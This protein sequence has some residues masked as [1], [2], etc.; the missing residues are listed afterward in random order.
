MTSGSHLSKE[1][2]DLVKSIGE[3]RS[4]QEEDRIISKEASLLKVK[5]GERN[6]PEKKLKELLIRAIYV[7]ML[8]HDASFAHIYA[9]NLTQSKNLLVKR[10]GYLAASLFID[11]NS[12]MIILMI[13]TMQK[14]LQSRNHFEVIAALNCLA[15][16]SNQSVMLAVQD[17]VVL[18]LDHQHEMIRK[19]AVMVLIKFNHIMPIEQMDQKMKKSLCDKDPSVMACALNY[20]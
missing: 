8:G 17:A 10:I 12:E 16:L 15:K 7:E 6:L 9:V 18:L 19:K 2:L 4:K 14:D 3:S 1:L 5:I 13:S 20:F 11:E